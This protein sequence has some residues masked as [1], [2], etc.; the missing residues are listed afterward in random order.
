MNFGAFKVEKTFYFCDSAFTAI[1]K[2][3]AKF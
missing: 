3:D 1:N 2:R